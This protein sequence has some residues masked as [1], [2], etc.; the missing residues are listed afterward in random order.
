MPRGARTSC[1]PRVEGFGLRVDALRGGPL[2]V[3]DAGR[4][5]A[6]ATVD[7]L[8]DRG[9]LVAPGS[10]LRRGRRRHVRVALTATDERIALAVDRA[11]LRQVAARFSGGCR[12]VG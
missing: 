5:T 1:A 6:W 2:P 9:I 4:A 8:A 12:V 10:L 7:G 3:G 11:G